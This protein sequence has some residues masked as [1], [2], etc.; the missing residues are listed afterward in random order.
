VEPRR[1]AS[2]GQLHLTCGFCAHANPRQPCLL[3]GLAKDHR[4]RVT[5]DQEGQ[6]RH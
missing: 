6:A 5:L 4:T 1:T 2:T 3:H